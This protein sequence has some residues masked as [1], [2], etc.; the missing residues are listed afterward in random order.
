MKHTVIA[1]AIA[2]T[3]ASL[4]GCAFFQKEPQPIRI[5]YEAKNADATGLIRAFDMKGNTVLQF[6]D[7]AKAKPAIYAGDDKT[8]LTYQVVGQ[9]LAVLPG[10]YPTLR[11]EA[12][13]ATATV[14]RSS[15][16]QAAA[17]AV[18][19]AEAGKSAATG[20]AAAV[21]AAAGQLG[22]L[23]AAQQTLDQARKDLAN[24]Q[25]AI[26]KQDEKTPAAEV[27][28]AKDQ[29]DH[30]EQRVTD[31]AKIILRVSFDFDSAKF[32]PPA[33]KQA[34]LLADAKAATLINVRGRTD[35][36]VADAPNYRIALARA[37][38]ARDWLAQRGIDTKKIRVFSLPA[39][40]FIADNSTEAGRRQNRRVEIELLGKEA[41]RLAMLAESKQ[42]AAAPATTIKN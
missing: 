19:V 31:A 17:P 32:E 5:Q 6:F 20:A 22:D 13:S 2:A 40:A 41:A 4:T 28:A 11:V 36:P 1:A 10:F 27:Q 12:N 25:Q 3:A 23:A 26:A 21:T 9:Q 30:I 24:V 34:Q 38:A 42:I 18:S 14:T 29:L 15:T 16:D 8:P 39:G 7:V 35:S 37:I 33:D